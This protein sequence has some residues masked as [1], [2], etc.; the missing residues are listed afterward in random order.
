M[1]KVVKL[2]EQNY[3]RLNMMAG[4]LRAGLGSPVSIDE[5]ISRLLSS[6]V[7]LTERIAHALSARKEIAACYLF[8]SAAKGMKAEDVDIGLLLEKG[9]AP[10]A[11]YEGEIIS[12]L[13]NAG[14]RNADIRLLNS[15]PARFLNQVLKYG[16]LVFSRDE[17]ARVEFE[18][19]ATKLYLDMA[20]HYAEYDNTRM[21]RLAHG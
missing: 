9:F 7:T 4:E 17:K 1:K 8:G 10:S 11:F 3:K 5:V 2:S 6:G 14:V 21:K 15:A 18:S 16:K 20:P 12:E 19:R 13:E